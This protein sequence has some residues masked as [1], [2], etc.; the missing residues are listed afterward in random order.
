MKP[1]PYTLDPDKIP[2]KKNWDITRA[3]WE[4][5]P[6][7]HYACPDSCWQEHHKAWC[8]EYRSGNKTAPQPMPCG[9]CC[10]EDPTSYGEVPYGCTNPLMIRAAW[11]CHIRANLNGWD[12]DL[13]DE[14]R[15]TIVNAAVDAKMNGEDIGIAHYMACIA[16]SI[17]S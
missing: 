16:V 3:A 4:G 2:T 15:S 5:G 10:F 8:R 17:N 14:Q 1:F 6:C 11:E 7:V 13:T 9:H 12:R